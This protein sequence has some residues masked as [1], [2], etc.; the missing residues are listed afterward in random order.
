MTHE[1]RINLQKEIQTM[2]EP[3]T[4]EKCIPA[5][6]NKGMFIF[7]VS[8][9]MARC[10][11]NGEIQSSKFCTRLVDV[12][13]DQSRT[14]VKTY[15]HDERPLSELL[16]L[17]TFSDIDSSNCLGNRLFEHFERVK[18]W[19]IFTMIHINS[20]YASQQRPEVQIG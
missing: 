8:Y 17:R 6:P 16:C 19:S 4:D 20:A 13:I 14:R 10:G 2:E 5:L 18:R 3:K 11:K 9:E 15:S 1:E 7:F 12:K